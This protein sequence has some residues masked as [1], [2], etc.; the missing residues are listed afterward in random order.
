MPPIMPGKT[1]W[2]TML[3][4]LLI[5]ARVRRAALGRALLEHPVAPRGVLAD[6][7]AARVDGAV[8]PVEL[9]LLPVVGTVIVPP[10]AAAE[11]LAA[12]AD[13]V[14]LVDEDDALAAPLAGELLRLAGEEAHDDRVDADEGL[15]EAGARDRDE[16][17]V[18][19]RSRSPSPSSSCR[20]RARRGRAGR[21]R[22]CRR[23]CSN[24]S[25]DCH[26]VTMRRISSLASAWPRTWSSLTPHSA[27]P[28]S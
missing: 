21:A 24:T 19:A 28:G 26:S 3:P 8:R 17:R 1:P 14:D 11:R 16:R 13:G 12:H 22:A 10:A 27:S 6:Q 18:E 15:R 5:P 20:C 2:L 9:R 23:R 7:V 25:P 4:S